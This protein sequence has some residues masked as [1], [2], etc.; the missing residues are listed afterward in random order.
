[1]NPAR[2]L[3]L[4]EQL[5]AR[6]VAMR[7]LAILCLLLLLREI[8]LA[9]RSIS[10]KGKGAAGSG[11]DTTGPP[12]GGLGLG[13]GPADGSGFVGLR[14]DPGCVGDCLQRDRRV[15]C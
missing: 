6:R 5:L 10:G 2:T 15:D 7:A 9:G 11:V 12:R 14:D 13:L 4:W 8:D 1:M 3:R